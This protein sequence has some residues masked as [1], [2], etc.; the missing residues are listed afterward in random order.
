LRA[1]GTPISSNDVLIGAI[2]L[3]NNLTLITHNIGEFSRIDG[4]AYEDWE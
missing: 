1:K 3:A 2:A 4:L